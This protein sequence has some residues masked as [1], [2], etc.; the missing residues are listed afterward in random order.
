MEYLIKL[1]TKKDIII[2]L[3][4]MHIYYKE[5]LYLY[6]NKNHFNEKSTKSLAGGT[7]LLK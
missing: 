3:I 1:E 6:T 2:R 7:A 5:P 4:N